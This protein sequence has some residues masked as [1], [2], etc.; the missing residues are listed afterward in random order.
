MRFFSLLFFL[1]ISSSGFSQR[2]PSKE[3]LTHLNAAKSHKIGH[4]Q[5]KTQLNKLAAKGKL[6]KIPQRGYGYRI[7]PL[8]HSHSYLVPKGKRV[9]NAI[10]RDFVKQA[11][12]NFFVVT[13]LT[14]TE[15]DQGRLRKSNVNAAS[16]DSSH[17]FGAA[18]DIS[19]VRFN[20]KKQ[21]NGKLEKKLEAVLQSYQKQGKIYYVK[22]RK[23]SCFHIVVR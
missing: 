7:A 4:I 20:N 21:P 16:N 12:Q 2:A 15:S 9:L 17:S 23:V 6:V 18:F 13:S 22:E 1:L 11:G 8:T 19:Y 5:N 3:Y 14:R 10:A